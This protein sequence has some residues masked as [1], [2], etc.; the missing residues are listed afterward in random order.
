M[1]PRNKKTLGKPA[2]PST[3]K[4]EN[5][6]TEQ[7]ARTSGRTLGYKETHWHHL[8]LDALREKPNVTHACKAAKVARRTAYDHRKS[9]KDFADAWDDALEEG[10]DLIELSMIEAADNG[11]QKAREFLLHKWRYSTGQPGRQKKPEEPKQ[12]TVA[13]GKPPEKS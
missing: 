8:F 7:I 5:Y 13:W 4:R 6:T 3:R 11:D 1:A 12:I 10:R 9:H 2:P